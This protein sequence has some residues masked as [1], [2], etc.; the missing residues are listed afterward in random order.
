MA[1]SVTCPR[2]QAELAADAR[3]C[4]NCGASLEI[5]RGETERR[6]VT[7]LFADLTG[8]TA[9]SEGRDPEQVKQIIDRAIARLSL[10]VERYG[11][12]VDKV[13]G[14]ELMAVFGA[15]SSHEDDPERATRAAFAM[16][17][18]LEA[19]SSDASLPPLR[20]HIGINTG[21]VVAGLVGG[22]DYTVLGDAVNIARRLQEA[23][24]PGQILVGEQTRALTRGSITYRPVGGVDAKGKALPVT[25][26]EAIA[27]RGL[28]GRIGALETPLI[29]RREEL[30]T[31]TLAALMAE[32]D[33]SPRI[34]T[35]VGDPGMGKS[36]IASE[37][38]S[39]GGRRKVRVLGGRS[40]PYAT[41]SPGFALEQVV[42]GALDLSGEDPEP[43]RRQVAAALQDLG[44][45]SEVEVLSAFLG[46]TEDRAGNTGGAPGAG[47][48]PTL[49][50]VI[51]ACS[52]LLVRIARR[53]G[54]LIVIWNDL[55]WAE[56]IVLEALDVMLREQDAPIL[57]VALARPGL[58]DSEPRYLRSSASFLL[59]LLPL[60][61]AR[62][63]EVLHA[64]GPDLDATTVEEIIRRAG[65]NPFFLEE[66]AR[67][68]RGSPDPQKVPATIHALV[69]AR[70][71]SLDPTDRRVL[72]LAAL[73]GDPLEPEII[74]ELTG[75]S[76]RERLSGLVESGFLERQGAAMRFRQ[77]VV[78]EVAVSS[79]PKQVRVELLVRL[80]GLLEAKIADQA[81]PAA[82][83][84]E[85][86]A[87][88][89]YEEAAITAR[90]IGEPAQDAARKA[91]SLL[92]RVGDR[93]RARDASRQAVTWY[94]RAIDVLDQPP[95]H[96]LRT[97]YAEALIGVLRFSEADE[98]LSLALKAAREAGDRAAEGRVL[99]LV[100]DAA[101]MQGRF[102]EAREALEGSLRIARDERRPDDLIDAERALGMLD[103]FAG[104][105]HSASEN[106]RTALERAR[107]V[108]DRR[109]EAW[110]LQS[111]GWAALMRGRAEDAID[112]FKQGEAIFDELDDHEGRGWCIGMRSWALLIIGQL[113]EAEILLAELDHMLTVEFPGDDANLVMARR[114]MTVLR[115]YL[116]IARA[117]LMTAEQISR[118]ILEEPDWHGQSWAH[119]LAAYPL[120]LSALFQRRLTAAD[121]AIRQGTHAAEQGG[122][123]FY[124]ALYMIAEAWLE[125]E[126]DRPDDAA[127]LLDEVENAPQVRSAWER[128]P[129]VIW[130]RSR[131]ATLR[132][133]TE[134]AKQI[135]AQEVNR[136]GLSLV[137]PS[138]PTFALSRLL[139]EDD[140]EAALSEAEKGL[141][142]AGGYT[143]ARL[144]GLLSVAD[145]ALAVGDTDRAQ[146]AALAAVETT[147]EGW[148]LMQ[149]RAHA[150]LARVYDRLRDHDRADEAFEKA[151][152]MFDGLPTDTDP[153]VQALLRG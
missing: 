66:L 152:Q 61:D 142:G 20:L 48:T 75:G 41:I 100:G 37:V 68:Y 42:R 101:R 51:E 28:P 78:R 7:V 49:P 84:S 145:A 38:I 137:P 29:G 138:W 132:G 27:E 110:A 11:G 10:I 144:A 130:L 23:A 148:P 106:F 54:L 141:A 128:S 35:L 93:A 85:E 76:A 70:L 73:A 17:S 103:L 60:S 140:P 151:R 95:G 57:F 14:D 69:A 56:D 105:W 74:E 83:L 122:D 102:E 88:S 86:R 96:D 31:I 129:M 111:L 80:A 126:R 124:R 115:A 1:T 46:L 43:Q 114:I 62:S 5:G 134:L 26:F 18:E 67:L 52:R 94:G 6:V 125:V 107:G 44:L 116:A 120:A 118:R 127:K 63:R 45:Q 150:M 8:F 32:R 19:M 98:E 108:G 112:S 99:R 123:P 13:I 91:R 139:L 39:E 136:Q 92:K 117:E 2:C 58:L 55:Q 21:E 87:A 121:Q 79:L 131:I 82:A 119:S 36:K 133:Q 16:H 15:P 71:D 109:G 59:P 47:A 90:E 4:S 97:R 143:L 33:R 34:V 104:D 146:E 89:A 50:R 135:L 77:K 72:Q 113:D 30:Q 153:R 3:F 149:A 9:L 147:T 12:R 25:A 81:G 22:R 24:Q 40:L 65:G 64:I 53:E